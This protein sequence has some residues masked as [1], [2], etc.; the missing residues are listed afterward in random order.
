MQDLPF[1]DP[2][3]LGVLAV[4]GMAGSAFAMY[5]TIVVLGWVYSLPMGK[6]A[7]LTSMEELLPLRGRWLGCAVMILVTL[8]A[9]PLM[10]LSVTLFLGCIAWL[11]SLIVNHR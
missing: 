5:G 2:L 9:V 3:V 10:L 11:I 7:R 4:V 6:H 1:K 8:V